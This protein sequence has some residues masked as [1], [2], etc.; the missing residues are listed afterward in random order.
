MLT[1]QRK[2]YNVIPG[3]PTQLCCGGESGSPEDFNEA[4]LQWKP[5]SVSEGAEREGALLGRAVADEY[6]LLRAASMRKGRQTLSIP[7]LKFFF[8]FFAKKFA[9]PQMFVV[10]L[11]SQT[12]MM[13]TFPASISS[14]F[15]LTT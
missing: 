4:V 5:Q 13:A 7:P 1:L 8:H 15:L 9:K 11:H 10:P 6:L 2:C 3:S 12:E 14:L